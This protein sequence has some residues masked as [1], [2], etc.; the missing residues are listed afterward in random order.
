MKQT[1]NYANQRILFT[2]FSLTP[3]SEALAGYEFVKKYGA[4]DITTLYWGD[5]SYAERLPEDITKVRIEA[6]NNFDPELTKGYDLVFRHQ[7]TRPELILS[8]ST[9]NTNEFFKYTSSPVIGVTGT[10]GKGTTTSLISRILSEAGVKNRLVGNIGIT[11]IAELDSISDEEVVVFELSSFQLWDLEYSPQ[12]AVVLMMDVDHQ[13][14]HSSVD[15]YVAAKHQIVAHQSPENVVIHHP[16]NAMSVQMV[17][18]AP[19]A[20]Q[21][22]FSEAGAHVRDDEIYMGYTRIM[23]VHEVGLRGGFN[24]ENVCAAIQASWLYT[25]DTEAIKQAVASFGGLEHR[26]ETV[27][28]VDEIEYVNDSFSVVP[29]AS[30]AAISA[31]SSPVVLIAGGYDRGANMGELAEAIESSSVK[32]VFLIGQTRQTIADAL[33]ATGFSAYDVVDEEVSMQEIVERAHGVAETGDTV[34]LSPGCAS[35]DQFKNYKDRG[36]QFRVAVGQP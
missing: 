30:V 16:D 17:E 22:Y 13:D 20:M 24:L 5:E 32:H 15:E 27:A 11:A 35:F 18:G 1:P 3:G 36:E 21:T 23:A 9:S 29:V 4:T 25:Q 10:K 6:Q 34:L 2:A 8:P 14:V 28:T 12:T 26:L 33:E 7:T 31:F 19:G